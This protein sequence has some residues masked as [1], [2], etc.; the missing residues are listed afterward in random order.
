MGLYFTAEEV[1][2]I[3]E[4]I[5]ENG[6]IFYRRAA[7]RATAEDVRKLLLRLAQDEE[8]HRRAFAQMRAGLTSGE[9]PAFTLSPEDDAAG[10]LHA[11]ADLVLFP[12]DA[13]PSDILGATPTRRDVLL[14]AIQ[15]EKDS[16][17]YYAGMRQIVPKAFGKMKVDAILREEMRHVAELARQIEQV[18]A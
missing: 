1:L 3:A 7:E 11:L 15:K 10:Y 5:E 8:G 16:V 6:V 12:R 13:N 4:R 2:T 14:T 9:K 18:G 17:A